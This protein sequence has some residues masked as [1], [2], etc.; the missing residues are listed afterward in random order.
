MR[1]YIKLSLGKK[2]TFPWN[3]CMSDFA[4]QFMTG[5]IAVKIIIN[6]F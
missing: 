6:V 5:D 4:V 3:S 2:L 1:D